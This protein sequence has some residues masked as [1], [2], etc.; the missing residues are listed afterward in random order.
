[1]KYLSIILV[2]SLSI[3]FSVHAKEQYID[4]VEVGLVSDQDIKFLC[5][6]I[7]GEFNSATVRINLNL[8]KEKYQFNRLQMINIILVNSHCNIGDIKRSVAASALFSNFEDFAALFQKYGFDNRYKIDLGYGYHYPLDIIKKELRN[9]E[10]TS[11]NRKV[12]VG[13]RKLLRNSTGAD[14]YTNAQMVTMSK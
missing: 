2:L 8:I 7:A 6:A 14:N 11:I 4:S 9:K 1:M 3:S 10:N 12:M 5:I 13:V